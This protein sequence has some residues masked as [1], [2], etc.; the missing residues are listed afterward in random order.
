M[1]DADWSVQYFCYHDPGARF[2]KE[3]YVNPELREHLGFLFLTQESR[4]S[5]ARS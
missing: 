3:E 5:Q 1:L 4:V 2:K